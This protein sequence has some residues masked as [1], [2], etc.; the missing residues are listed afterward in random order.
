[1]TTDKCANRYSKAFD[2]KIDILR[3][4]NCAHHTTGEYCELCEPGYEGDA[5]R[6]TPN[7][8]TY[9]SPRPE[10][11]RCSAAGSR[12]TSC[13]D[14]RCECKRNVEGPECNRCR[15]STYGLRAENIDGCIECYCSG[16]TDQCH[17][18]TLYVQQIPMWVYDSHHGFTLTDS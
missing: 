18:S 15:P 1:M 11:C 17:E 3:R 9:R 4:Q 13:I 14:G 2:K 5:S 7:D 16:V 10:P 8:C 12:S 6:G